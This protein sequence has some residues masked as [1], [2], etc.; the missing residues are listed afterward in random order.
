MNANELDLTNARFVDELYEAYRE[1]PS[2]VDESWRAYFGSWDAGTPEAEPSCGSVVNGHAGAPVSAPRP[3]AF[4]RHATARA[5]LNAQY[6]DLGDTPEQAWLQSRVDT[7]LWAYRDVGYLYANLNP[8]GDYMT[9]EMRYMFYTSE[10]YYQSLDPEGF[11]LGEEHMEMQFSAGK[12]FKPGRATLRELIKLFR[13]TYC[14]TMGVEL[15]HIQNKVMRR[16][17]IERIEDPARRRDFTDE[18]RRTFQTDLIHAEELERFIH[19]SFIGQKRF[20]LEGAEVVIP[21]L[22]YLVGS[23]SQHGLHE[24]VLG[25]AH[26]G[27]LNVLINIMKKKAA[28]VFAQFTDHYKPYVFGGSGDVKYHLGHSRDVDFEDGSR[29]HMSLV[30][31]PSHLEAVNPVV[32][33]KTRGIQRRR[34][35]KHR[36][37]VIPVLIHGD[38]AFSGQGVVAET[39]NMSQLKGYR[40]G[41]TVHIIIN[42][43]IGFTTAGRDARST[44]FTTDIAKSLPIPIFHVNGDDP[45]Q[46][47]R[48]IDLSMRYR[49]KFGLDAVVDILCFRRLGHNESDEPSF[50]HPMMYSRIKEHPGTTKMYGDILSEQGVFSQED[51]DAERVAFRSSLKAELDLAKSDDYEPSINDAFQGADWKDKQAGYTHDQGQTAVD[52]DRLSH[53]AKCLVTV[54]DDFSLHPK[55]RR[56]VEDREKAFT[57]GDGIDWSFA[58]SLAFGAL[59]LDGYPIR[60]SGEDTSRGTFS[61]RHAKWWDVSSP[62]PRTYTPLRNLAPDQAAFSVY[63]SPLSEFGVLGFD[64][65]YSIAQPDL[66]TL[67]EAQ[68]GDFVNGAQVIIDQFI[69]AAETKWFRSSGLVMLLPHGY[70]GQ[71]PEHS[72]AHLERFLQLCAEDNLQVCNPSTPANYFHVLRRQLKRPFRKPLILMTP[73]S[74]LRRKECVSKV[75]EFTSACFQTVIDDD[76]QAAEGDN[77]LLCSGKVYYDLAAER[78]KR[79]DT[80][81]AIVRL[82]QFYPRPDE[83]MQN[84]LSSYP[85]AKRVAWVQEESR[86]R[87]GWTFVHTWIE[88]MLGRPRIDYAGRPAAASPAAGSH[89]DHARQ[90]RDILETAFSR[91]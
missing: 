69:A 34:G 16:W 73:K 12:Y 32:E 13:S 50:T 88:D 87:G 20:S 62:I 74:L 25:M 22:R 26:R 52:P 36:K 35:D 51:Q 28:D 78:D 33:G 5:P 80:K 19:T 72:S 15:L 68:F 67:W 18:Q 63:D 8:L 81:T 11:G 71:G 58:E 77:L 48:A 46:V 40:T 39:F 91:G 66:L 38:A 27:R 79:G 7:L 24:I 47:V 6:E 1:N 54:P 44:F 65:G 10:G 64:Y 59:L 76:V 4:V 45:E 23:A 75:T 57:D 41:G 2:S 60:L 14:G 53:I 9:P 83:R 89:D 82:E 3:A 70:E 30:A 31:N 21:A 17:L 42:N 43:Q 29:I 86:N 56:F 55:L 84:V 49:Q 85:N 37:K 61:Q 90:L